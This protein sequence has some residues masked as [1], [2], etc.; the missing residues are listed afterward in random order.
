[1]S[2]LPKALVFDLDGCV[3]DPELYEL[4]GGSP[5]S[6]KSDGNLT[7]SSGTHL[8]LMG[9]VRKIMNELKNDSK[10]SN[11]VVAIASK[12]TELQ[13]AH[14]CLEKFQLEDSSNNLKSV[15]HPDLME[16]YWDNKQ[17]HLKVI[18]EKSGIQLEDMIFFDNQMDNCRDVSQIGVTVSY[19]PNGVTRRA[20]DKVIEAFPSPGQIIREK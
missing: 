17:R 6:T 3:W 16:I 10:W 1:M 9:D 11:T 18:A 20:F 19:V 13:W 5:F 7:D 12:C 4:H 8:Y 15:F 14:E 2:Q